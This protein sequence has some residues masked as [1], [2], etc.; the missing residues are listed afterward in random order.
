MQSY[1]ILIADDSEI[2]RKSIAET[3]R[4]DNAENKLLFA[5]DG[6]TACKIAFHEKPDL[7]LI[8]LI[9]PVM[10]GLKAIEILRKHR[11]TTDIP[12]IAMS[13]TTLL[14]DAY[15]AGAND[16]ISKPFREYELLL[17]IRQAMSLLEKIKQIKCQN[18]QL[19]NQNDEVTKQR[20]QLAEK[21]KEIIDDINYA[22]HIQTALLPSNELLKELLPHH[23]IFYRP[24]SIVSGDFYWVA[25]KE[26]KTIVAA[27]DCTGHG[28]SGAFM[29][30]AGKAFL[31]EVASMKYLSTASEF[32]NQLRNRVMRL[33][34]QRGIL[35]EAS[36]GM[37][38][39]L[40]ILDFKDR[41]MQCAGANNP[42][43][44]VKSNGELQIIK[45]DKIPIGIHVNFTEPF[46]AHDLKLGKGDMVYLFSDGYADQFGGPDNQKFRYKHLQELFVQVH[47]KPLK[48]QEKIIE[49]TFIDWLGQNSQIDDIMVLGIRMT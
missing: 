23:F 5:T 13:S 37:D 22:L 19:I 10:G 26:N 29:T 38:I 41:T 21:N 16:F 42:I 46:T 18:E 4:H 6:K 27:A 39:S 25:K 32:L 35:G 33:L 11:E 48:E 49:N 40:C 45:P 31:D 43:Y 2:V 28:I 8:D 20:N 15:D 17:R 34:Q 3:F 30:I 44:I 9:M 47:Q 7:I 14:K 1:K 36:D 12:I 24:K